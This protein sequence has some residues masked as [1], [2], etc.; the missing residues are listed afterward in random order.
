MYFVEGAILYCFFT[1]PVIYT[2]GERNIEIIG[3]HALDT[4][5][6]SVFSVREKIKKVLDI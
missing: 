5:L 3:D 4:F 1:E 2:T 6:K